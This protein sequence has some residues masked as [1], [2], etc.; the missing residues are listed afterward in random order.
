[1][2][3]T[4]TYHR[5]FLLEN[6]FS[7]MVSRPSPWALQMVSL[8]ANCQQPRPQVR[9]DLHLQLHFQ[10]AQQILPQQAQSTR[11]RILQLCHSSPRWALDSITGKQ[12]LSRG[13]TG[14]CYRTGKTDRPWG[15]SQRV[16]CAACLCLALNREVNLLLQKSSSEKPDFRH[17]HMPLVVLTQ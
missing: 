6:P 16:G 17:T 2:H 15:N 11:P 3:N 8:Q 9:R 10:A 14:L 1:M 12:V 13:G 5:F 7:K 4:T